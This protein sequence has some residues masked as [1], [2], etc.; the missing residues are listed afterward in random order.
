[1]RVSVCKCRQAS[2]VLVGDDPVE[3]LAVEVGHAVGAALQRGEGHER[4]RWSLQHLAADDR[5]DSDDGRGG[6][7]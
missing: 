6:G 2:D 7:R 5:A 4:G 3:Q 1:M